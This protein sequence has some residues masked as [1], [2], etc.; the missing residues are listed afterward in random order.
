MRRR[1]IL[2]LLALAALFSALPTAGATTLPGNTSKVDYENTDSDRYM[3]EVDLTNQVITVY[4]KDG[5]GKF[6]SV[7]LQGLCTTGNEEF[8]TGAGTYRLGDL[9]ERFGYFVAFGQYAQYWS[10][11]VRGVYIHSVLYDSTKLTSMSRSAY[12]GLGKA[13]SHGCIRV[14]PEVA[15]W[16]FYN[17]PPGTLCRITRSKPADAALVKSIKAAMASYGEYVHPQ[18]QKGAPPVIPAIVRFDKTPLRSGFSSTRDKTLA[19]LKAGDKLDLLQIGSEWVKARTSGGKLGYVKTALLR[20]DPDAPVASRTGYIATAKT[21]VYAFA[22][23]EA[24]KVT[25]IPKGAEVTVSESPLEGWYVGS[26]NGASG[27]LRTKYVAKKT[28]L[29][30]PSL[31]DPT[32]GGPRQA[33]VKSTLRA[34]FRD[35]PTTEGSAILAVL[36]PGT[37]VTLFSAAGN[38]Y[39]A[40]ANGLKGYISAVC[41]DI[42]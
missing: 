17:C 13:L 38:W 30:Y 26:Y 32:S 12:N 29:V 41:L 18:D 39:Y 31:D 9:K 23:T 4:A 16:I 22:S 35:Q 11:V 36:D 2:L 14:L 33:V 8:P 3:I 27:Y 28:V 24:Q 42:G 10:Q 20:F 5:S 40:E 15:Q 37:P 6:A 7:V 25:S 19:T 1:F 21:Y 34:S